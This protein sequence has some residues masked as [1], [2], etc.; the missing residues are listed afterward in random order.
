M[1]TRPRRRN[2]EVILV[3]KTLPGNNNAIRHGAGTL[4]Q[5]LAWRLEEGIGAVRLADGDGEG[6]VASA[7]DAA[8]YGV[9]TAHDMVDNSGAAI[10]EPEPTVAALRTL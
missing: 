1:N 6:W 10:D 7:S 4:G 2:A 9:L 3:S 8:S 5:Q